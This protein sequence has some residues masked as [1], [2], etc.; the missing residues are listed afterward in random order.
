[1]GAI[2]AKALNSTLGTS[3]FKG[4]DVLL[5]E[6][7]SKVHTESRQLRYS[8]TEVYANIP[9]EI[10]TLTPD[11]LATSAS[12]ETNILSFTL[13]YDGTIGLQYKF[14][15]S[16]SSSTVILN[17]KI[18][19]NN[20]LYVTKS[21]NNMIGDTDNILQL[22]GVKGD[23]FKIAISCTNKSTGALVARTDVYLYLRNLLATIIEGKSMSFSILK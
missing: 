23:V 16:S 14:G 3:N 21:T 9:S 8:E 13:P 6:T 10:A 1:M 22:S 11:N 5:Y 20:T 4:F 7:L 17:L 2:T 19:R 18:Y 15:F 12:A